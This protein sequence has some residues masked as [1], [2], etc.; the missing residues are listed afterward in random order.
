MST[1]GDF[2]AVLQISSGAIS[3]LARAMHA[4]GVIGHAPM[5][6]AFDACWSFSADAP[7]ASFELGG[8]LNE[9][10]VRADV[11]VLA[12]QTPAQAPALGAV[13]VIEGSVPWRAKLAVIADPA[14]ISSDLVLLYDEAATTP[15][16]FTAYG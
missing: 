13:A 11:R 5:V 1:T 15:S 12:H 2:S 8:G 6:Q 10:R 9:I 16:L 3:A 4:Q 14:P 7:A